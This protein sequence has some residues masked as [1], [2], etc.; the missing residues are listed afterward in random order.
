MEEGVRLADPARF[1]VRGDLLCAHDV[2]ID[3]NCVFEGQ[4][5]LGKG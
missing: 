5:N 1:D 4:V 3:V 2:S